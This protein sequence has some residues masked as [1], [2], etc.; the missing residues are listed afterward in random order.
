MASSTAPQ[1][2]IEDHVKE[3][4]KELMDDISETL[5]DKTPDRCF[6]AIAA[7]AKERAKHV[8]KY[9]SPSLGDPSAKEVADICRFIIEP[10]KVQL[11]EIQET[12]DA[13]PLHEALQT[14]YDLATALLSMISFI[15][16]R[17]GEDLGENYFVFSKVIYPQLRAGVESFHKY[18][19][20]DH[21]IEK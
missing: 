12:I 3:T 19:Q 13:I 16:N 21:R 17:Y 15:S 7:F 11:K 10:K 1:R 20:S 14:T 18:Q 5:R 9:K 2:Q 8:K 4:E 6:Q